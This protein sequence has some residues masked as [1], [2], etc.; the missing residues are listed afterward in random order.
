MKTKELK[1]IAEVEQ[2]MNQLQRTRASLDKKTAETN[3]KIATV[4]DE[5]TESIA[6]LEEEA[7]RLE[8]Q[9]EAWAEEHR[10][11]EELFP[12]G[13]KTLDLQAGT[14]SFRKGNA[15]VV[16]RK[17]TK[18]ADVIQFLSNTRKELFKS[19]LS[20][21][22]PVLDKSAVK[23]AYDGGE[24]DADDLQAIGLQIDEGEETA[25]IKLKELSA[26]DG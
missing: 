16:L 7:K 6:D 19:F 3:S 4:R 8:S 10:G 13:K 15:K 1:S 5:Y 21:P 11:D 26:Y 22:D 2:A 25:S 12:N 14:I 9:L 18:L 20:M 23:E 17:K 24:I